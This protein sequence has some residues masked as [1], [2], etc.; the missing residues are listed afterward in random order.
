MKHNAASWDRAL[1]ALAGMV[2]NLIGN[3]T[4][5]GGLI[6]R[7]RLDRRSYPVGRKVS[8]LEM[9]SLKIDAGSFRGDW[10]YIVRPRAQEP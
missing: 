2:V 1:R 8:A 9:R 10:N 6:V 3:T 5:R 4:N 7:A